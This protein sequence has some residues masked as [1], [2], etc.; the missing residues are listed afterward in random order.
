MWNQVNYNQSHYANV[1]TSAPYN[2][3]SYPK[4]PCPHQGSSGNGSGR[5]RR[6]RGQGGSTSGFPGGSQWP[7]LLNPWTGSIHMWPG[8]TPDGSRGPPPRPGPS[9]SP[10]LQQHALVA[11]V[12]PTFY[13]STQGTY[14]QAP[15]QAPPPAWTPAPPPTPPVWSPWD[16]QSLAN[17]FSTVTLTPPPNSSD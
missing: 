1:G 10:P 16:Q 17:A 11:G 3:C 8:S 2:H 7:S 14:H 15:T 12:P 4:V 13:P 9:A 5:G 6:R